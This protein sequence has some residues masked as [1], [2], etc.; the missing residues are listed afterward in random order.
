MKKRKGFLS[1]LFAVGCIMA[2][3]LQVFAAEPESEEQALPEVASEDAVV[4]PAAEEIALPEV[5]VE[6]AT[7]ESPA[8]E[9]ALPEIPAEDATVESP[10]EEIA[11]PEVP[12][13]DAVVADPAAISPR[14]GS[15]YAAH[16]TDYNSDSFYI[17]VTGSYSATGKAYIKAWDFSGSPYVYCT[18][19]RPDNSVAVSNL[20]LPLG[21]EVSRS[22]LDLP[23]GSYR[24]S[25]SVIGSGKGW[26][27]CN[28]VG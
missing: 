18:L 21:Q 8:E 27:Y 17:N 19:Y 13:E 28:L 14:N 9:I 1:L 20:Q 12:S 10:A 5:P 26:I 15:G 3:N 7:V 24:L 23:T 25:Y 4:A 11:L 22:F 2:F 6:D 16:Y